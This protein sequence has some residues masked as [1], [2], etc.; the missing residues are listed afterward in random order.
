MAIQQLQ[1]SHIFYVMILD[2]KIFL[3]LNKDRESNLSAMSP[4][5]FYLLQKCE[6]PLKLKLLTNYWSLQHFVMRS[7]FA[8][9]RASL[10]SSSKLAAGR[11][12]P[13]RDNS[14]AL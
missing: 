8:M 14:I 3:F 12:V 1:Q 7:K 13:A 6:W 5:T 4:V 9:Q 11:E 2:A 10:L